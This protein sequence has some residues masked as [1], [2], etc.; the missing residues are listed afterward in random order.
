[1]A[2]EYNTETRNESNVNV[3][4]PNVEEFPA[5]PHVAVAPRDSAAGEEVVA[6]NIEEADDTQRDAETVPEPIVLRRSSRIRK[7]PAYLKDFET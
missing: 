6:S 5:V 3:H 7:A 1:M 4:S 2:D